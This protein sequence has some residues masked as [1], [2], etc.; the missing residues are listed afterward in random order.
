MLEYITIA[1]LEL[2]TGLIGLSDRQAA[3]RSRT[4]KPVKGRKGVYE[5]LGQVFFKKGERI[6]LE[7][8]D[9]MTLSKVEPTP[10]T[11]E[12]LAG[13]VAERIE[14]RAAVM[15]E[16]MAEKILADK[17]LQNDPDPAGQG[18]MEI[19]GQIGE[20]DGIGQGIQVRG[21]MD[22]DVP[23]VMEAPAMGAPLMEIPVR[24]HPAVLNLAELARAAG[25]AIE[26]GRVTG[27][28]APEV[29]A[30]EEILGYDVTA[31]QRDEAWKIWKKEQTNA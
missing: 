14:A 23:P 4:L 30:M 2:F 25:Q 18:S 29:A 13:Q 17:I 24:E 27:S 7:N 28:G 15:A 12:F 8:P 19:P 22:D 26:A 11:V 3:L 31:G 9:K 20:T 5:I 1:I 16:Q 6:G 10:E 21:F